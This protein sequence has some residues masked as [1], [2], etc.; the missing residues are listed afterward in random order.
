MHTK[1]F[2]HNQP[3]LWETQKKIGM[4]LN[5]EQFKFQEIALVCH[6]HLLTASGIEPGQNKIKDIKEIP[7]PE[8]KKD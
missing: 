6:G 4:T 8:D 3:C 7:G 2:T 1:H 5:V